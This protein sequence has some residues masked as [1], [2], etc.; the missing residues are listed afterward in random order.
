MLIR[1]ECISACAYLKDKNVKVDLAYIDPPFASGADYAKKVY[2]RKNLKVAEAIAQAEEELD[3]EELRAFEEKMYGDIWN[4]EDYLN[5]MYENLT[6]IKSV[7]SET[8]MMTTCV[9]VM[10]APKKSMPCTTGPVRIVLT[11][12]PNAAM[13]KFSTKMKMPSEASM[14][15]REFDFFFRSGLKTE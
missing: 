1:G 4:K 12:A 10:M 13:M 9:C 8:A 15:M 14:R 3:L 7:M 2:L 6:A 5:W 11:S